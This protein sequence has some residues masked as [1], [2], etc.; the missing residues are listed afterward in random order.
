MINQST[1][2][3]LIEMRLTSMADAFRIQMDDPAMTLS[4]R[5]NWYD[6]RIK[7]IDVNPFHLSDDE[8]EFYVY[9]PQLYLYDLT[10][11]EEANEVKKI[12]KRIWNIKENNR[13][14]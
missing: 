9:N 8:I 2:D 11:E 1:T 4:L 14:L 7:K 13:E 12:I 6:S 3:K 5:F 10:K